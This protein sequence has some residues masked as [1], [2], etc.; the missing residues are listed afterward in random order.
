MT[1]NLGDSADGDLSAGTA[2]GS[3]SCRQ[4]AGARLRPHLLPG[5]ARPAVREGAAGAR[6]H[7]G[8]SDRLFHLW[9]HHFLAWVV[10]IVWACLG[11][12]PAGTARR[13]WRASTGGQ[14]VPVPGYRQQAALAYYHGQ[15]A[16]LPPPG[17]Y[18][19]VVDTTKVRWWDGNEWTGDTRAASEPP[20]A[21]T[22]RPDQHF[23]PPLG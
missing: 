11:R 3:C 8:G 14:G 10:S 12:P 18:P 1:G 4:V 19:D 16:P 13:V 7:V 2:T 22:R 20:A 21:G 9:C 6:P 5:S 23:P 17:W 15:D